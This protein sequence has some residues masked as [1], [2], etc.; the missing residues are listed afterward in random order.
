MGDFSLPFHALSAALNFVS[1][2]FC[3]LLIL[4]RPLVNSHKIFP[5]IGEGFI[6]HFFGGATLNWRIFT[7]VSPSVLQL[8]KHGYDFFGLVIPSASP[9]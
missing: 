2:E 7:R 6:C 4:S 9:L 3:R 5:F 8:P 1:I